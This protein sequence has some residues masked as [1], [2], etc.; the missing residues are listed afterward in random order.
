MADEK[1]RGIVEIL[2]QRIGLK[3][4]REEMSDLERRARQAGHTLRNETSAAM[5]ALKDDAKNTGSELQ[6][7]GD[8]GE[9]SIDRLRRSV[10]Q[11]VGGAVLARFV[12]SSVTDFAA[13][14]RQI[15]AVGH[16]MDQLGLASERNLPKLRAF[17]RDL[18]AQTGVLQQQ[19]VPAYQKFLGITKSVEGA[20]Y[21]VGLAADLTAAGL[22]DMRTNAERLANLLQ[23]EVTEAAKSLGLQLRDQNGIVKTQ[24][25]LL[26]ELI[27]LYGGFARQQ[28]DAQAEID[29]TGA[30]WNQ[31]RLTVGES[32][33]QFSGIAAGFFLGIFR[34]IQSIGPVLLLIGGQAIGVFNGIGRAAAAA[35]NPVNW[36]SG[37]YK[38]VV[39]GQF[40]AAME[41]VTAGVEGAIEELDAIWSDAGESQA[42]A[43]ADGREKGRSDLT[44]IA[45]AKQKE[46]D[47]RAAALAAE[48]AR[49]EAEKRA[50]F[51]LAAQQELLRAQLALTADGSQERLDAEKAVLEF[52]RRR[53]L[54]EAERL[55]ADTATITETFRLAEEGLERDHQEKLA[56]IRGQ[57]RKERKAA[58]EEQQRWAR[59]RIRLEVENA[60]RERA[61]TRETARVKREQALSIAQASVDLAYAVFGQNKAVAI[62]EVVIRTAMGVMAALASLPPNIPLAALIAAIG[63]AQLAKVHSAEPGSAGSLSGAVGGATAAVA[64][65]SE[66]RRNDEQPVPVQNFDNRN[67]RDGDSVVNMNFKGPNIIDRRSMQRLNREL[68][69]VQ[70]QDSARRYR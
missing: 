4:G 48:R 18:E 5:K 23:G 25:Q 22:G 31:L 44:A 41:G 24:T 47:D 53:A 59:E 46:R 45:A 58:F 42:E 20:Q 15:G 52:A 30:T 6:K 33:A 64:T 32:F 54:E 39:A 49:Q 17:L 10:V 1:I 7:M 2:L 61:E 26:D 9:S 3:E 14:D 43:E 38:A 27:T 69:R 56:K 57:E 21:A 34:S 19:A 16:Q 12:Q 55:G 66:T 51:E 40:K 28:H 13:L 11:Y 65:G 29:K 36:F 70:R 8:K 50:A 37:D 63:A 62:A 68:Q 67:F 35:F 60:A